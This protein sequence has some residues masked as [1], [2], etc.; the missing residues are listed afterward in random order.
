MQMFATLKNAKTMAAYD[1]IHGSMLSV[2]IVGKHVLLRFLGREPTGTSFHIYILTQYQP[3]R[4]SHVHKDDR[5]DRV[6]YWV[7]LIGKLASD[8]DPRDMCQVITAHCLRTR[9][10]LFTCSLQRAFHEMIQWYPSLVSMF[11]HFL[12]LKLIRHPR[13]HSRR[14]SRQTYFHVNRPL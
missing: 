3:F 6:R 2:I 12:P 11:V 7:C 13:H 14:A 8:V 9:K 5:I 10:R 1:G 4:D